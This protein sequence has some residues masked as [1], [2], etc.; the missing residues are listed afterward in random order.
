MKVYQTL[1]H[2]LIMAT[3]AVIGNSVEIAKQLDAV[4]AENAG[5][6]ILGVAEHYVNQLCADVDEPVKGPGAVFNGDEKL[7]FGQVK[8]RWGYDTKT[9][10][11]ILKEGIKSGIL[12]VEGKG[13]SKKYFIVANQPVPA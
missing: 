3:F 5:K 13:R 11:K 4:G 10:T 12:G 1:Q 8:S 7:Y 2:E 6:A 9:V